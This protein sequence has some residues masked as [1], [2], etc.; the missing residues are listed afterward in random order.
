MWALRVPFIYAR[1]LIVSV[2]VTVKTFIFSGMARSLMTV[3]ARCALPRV[4]L[5]TVK[6]RP[7]VINDD[8]TAGVGLSPADR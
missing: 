3:S 1:A 8:G 7:E 4:V 6:T 2:K 5:G